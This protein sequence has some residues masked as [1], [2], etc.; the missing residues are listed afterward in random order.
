MSQHQALGMIYTDRETASREKL[1]G[2]F[3]F[4]TEKM[5]RLTIANKALT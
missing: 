4:M 5:G 1:M 2:I 3:P